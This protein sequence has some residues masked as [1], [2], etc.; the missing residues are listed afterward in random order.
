MPPPKKPTVFTATTQIPELLPQVTLYQHTW[1]DH[2][3]LGHNEMDGYEAAVEETISEP[4]KILA[5]NSVAGNYLFINENVTYGP[6]RPLRVAVKPVATPG[7][8]GPPD[9][10]VVS[11]YF[12]SN[13]AGAGKQ[14]WP[15]SG[16]PKK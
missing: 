12:S 9:G 10:V 8:P 6:N 11:S 2:I 14:I 3:V 16:K 7:K 1:Q 15:T 13:V 5:S 4:T